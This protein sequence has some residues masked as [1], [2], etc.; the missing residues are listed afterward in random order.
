LPSVFEPT[1]VAEAAELMRRATDEGQSVSIERA[2]GDVVIS[3]SRLSRLL[4]HEPGDLTCIVEAGMRLSELQ[5]RLGRHGQVLM[6]DPPGD[7]TIG[8]CL[9]AGLSGPRRHR[10]GA[11]RDLVL[12]VTV[13]LGD[14][15]VA[16]SGGRVVKNVAGYDLGK[17][18]CGSHGRLGLIAAVALRLHPR[19]VAAGSLSVKTANPEEAQRLVQRALRS[20]LVPSALDLLWPGR[21]L[22]LFEG[23]ERAVA[24]LLETAQ[25]VLSGGE[26]DGGAWQELAE[27]QAAARGRIWFDPGRL[28]EFLVETP[29]AVVRVAA[30]NAY[31]PNLV[32]HAWPPLAERVRAEFDPGGVLVA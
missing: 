25:T 10:Y 8:A 26:E 32:G 31:V 24:A 3:T 6:L 28:A 15:T 14:G 30:G 23:S 1:T 17:L 27:R 29:E 13:V 2:G 5:E 22:L 21:L 9:A 20:Q 12:G 4:E 11:M 7:P 18:F 19:P 16:H